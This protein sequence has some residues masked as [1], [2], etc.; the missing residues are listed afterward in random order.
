MKGADPHR[1][2]VEVERQT[3]AYFLHGGLL[4]LPRRRGWESSDDF[5]GIAREIRMNGWTAEIRALGDDGR[6]M[7]FEA[8]GRRRSDFPLT[9]RKGCCT[10]IST[11]V[12]KGRTLRKRVRRAAERRKLHSTPESKRIGLRYS[13]RKRNGF[14]LLAGAV[15]GVALVCGAFGTHAAIEGTPRAGA[16]HYLGLFGA[17]IRPNDGAIFVVGAKCLV[18][19]STDKGKSW[20]QLPIRVR[21]GGPLFQD[22]DLYSIAFAP[23]GKTG[24]IVGEAGTALN[25]DDGG[26]TWK[27]VNT[28]TTKTLLKV[29]VDGQNVVAV[30]ADGAILRSTDG[31][32]SWQMEK[33][34]LDITLFDVTFTDPNT[35]WAAGEFH[36]ILKSADGGQSWT[37]ATGG[38]T[39]NFEIGPYFTINFI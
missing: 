29:Y 9:L 36:T 8:A 16:P 14:K 35:A 37:I 27:K 32:T 33:C 39:E 10:R 24:V 13:M 2:R 17:S 12:E 30:G 34:P 26:A 1:H 20:V 18:M 28:G 5:R 21:P 38:H 19:V 3:N 7:R 25:T 6:R 15:L 22:Y 11:S 4:A 31:G 23:D